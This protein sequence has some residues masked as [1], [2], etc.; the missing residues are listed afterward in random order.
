MNVRR[1]FKR[2]WM[3][4]ISFIIFLY[5]CVMKPSDLPSV[6]INNFDKFVHFIMHLG[7]SLLIFFEMTSY[8][9]NATSLKK[10]ILGSWIAPVIYGGAI[11]LIQEYLPVNRTGDWIDFYYDVGGATLGLVI[12]LII[13]NIL[14][15]REQKKQSI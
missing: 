7:I 15:R 5:L 13:N 10:I 12:C 2:H 1:F 8:F 11:E 3:S 4:S 9:R 14:K 6:S